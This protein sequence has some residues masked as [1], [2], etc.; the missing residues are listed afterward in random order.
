MR[1]GCRLIASLY[2]D[3]T[4]YPDDEAPRPCEAR[5]RNRSR[6]VQTLFGQIALR[7]H[8]YHHQP[9]GT[10]RCPLDETLDLT[11]GC[12][13]SVARLMLRAASQSHS[14]EQA[15]ADLDI[16]AGL[17]LDASISSRCGCEYKFP[18]NMR[19]LR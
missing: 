5:H 16:Y 13:P 9:S 3:R 8:Y 11:C 10:G 15:A 17:A 6:A 12:T 1:D 19:S 14:Y 4:L 2:N 18:G 7:R